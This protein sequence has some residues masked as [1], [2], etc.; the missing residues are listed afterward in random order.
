[1]ANTVEELEAQ[2]RQAE[3]SAQQQVEDA[4]QQAA[5]E[6]QAQGAT[7]DEVKAAVEKARK[8]E[9]DKLYPLIEELKNSIKELQD[10][11]RTEREEKDRIKAEAEA[12]KERRR[13]EKLSDSEKTIEAIKRLEEKLAEEREERRKSEDRWETH[14]RETSLQTYR[15]RVIQAA[16]DEIIP[17]LVTGNTEAEIDRNAEIAKTRYAEL[18]AQFKNEAGRTIREGMP[19]ATGPGME[20]LEEEELRQQFNAVDQDKYMK[21]PAYRD[22]VKAQLE[23]AY[24]RSFGR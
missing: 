3:Q 14:R 13:Q 11:A 19:S 1:M 7:P 23:N 17:E 15:D 9:K 8:E 4:A 22:Q 20:A 5:Q 21:D 16:G 24:A 10:N 6:A 18:A 2:Q 12:E